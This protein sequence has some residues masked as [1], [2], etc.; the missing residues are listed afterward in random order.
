M[1]S[2]NGLDR[3]LETEARASELILE[4]ENEAGAIVGKA[5]DEARAKEKLIL[6]EL[7]AALEAALLAFG[8]EVK[9][10]SQSEL[11]A[12][13]SLLASSP[14]NEDAFARSCGKFL[15]SRD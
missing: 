2:L 15:S 12:F 13:R 14:R 1:D 9:L 10:K 8:S 4:A 6:S 3:L 7:G 5:N 11:E